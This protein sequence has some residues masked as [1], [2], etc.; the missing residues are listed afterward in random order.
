MLSVS[1]MSAEEELAEFEKLRAI[2][3][4]HPIFIFPLH[5]AQIPREELQA[6][7]RKWKAKGWIKV[8][9]YTDAGKWLLA[10]EFRAYGPGEV[11]E[12]TDVERRKYV[13]AAQASLGE[14]GVLK[15]TI[16]KTIE[17]KVGFLR[18]LEEGIIRRRK[19][20]GGTKV[21]ELQE[22]YRP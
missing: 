1:T 12:M 8:A 5:R 22:A 21:Y 16:F 17:P 15:M 3:I 10:E 9:H 11:R 14:S 7:A 4:E 18:L 20:E 19:R 2:S 13:A 6:L